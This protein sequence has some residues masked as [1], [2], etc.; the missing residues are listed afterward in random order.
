MATRLVMIRQILVGTNTGVAV[1]LDLVPVEELADPEVV[2]EVPEDEP[3]ITNA[4]AVLWVETVTDPTRPDD[5]TQAACDLTG[6][7]AI[8]ANAMTSASSKRAV[9]ELRNPESNMP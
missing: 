9:I 1:A 3:H 4:D 5:S 2:L 7:D 6:V 8:A